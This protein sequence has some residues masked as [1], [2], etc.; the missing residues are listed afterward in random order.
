MKL[1]VQFHLDKN[2]ISSMLHCFIFCGIS[3]VQPE[4]ARDIHVKRSGTYVLQVVSLNKKHLKILDLSRAKHRKFFQRILATWWV[5]LASTIQEISNRTHWTDP[6]TWV[7]NSSSNLLRGPLVR[8]HSIFDENKHLQFWHVF[9]GG[10]L[11]V[12]PVAQGS[13]LWAWGLLSWENSFQKF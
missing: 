5:F 11:K 9:F 4:K 8:S 13:W 7:S 1:D 12:Q 2:S 6:S 3:G 10:V